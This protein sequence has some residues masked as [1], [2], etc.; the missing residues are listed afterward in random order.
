M[1]DNFYTGTSGIVLPVANKTQYPLEFQA[2]SRLTYYSHLFNSLEI[3]SSFYKVPMAKTVHKWA[4]EVPDDFRFTFKLWRDITHV[5]DLQFRN[6]DVF[7]FMDVIRSAG[8]KKGCLLVQFPPG[9]SYSARPQLVR[10]LDAICEANQ[11]DNWLVF[12]EF[13]KKEWYSDEMLN[14][15]ATYHVGLVLH[16]KGGPSIMKS[17]SLDTAIYLRFHGPEGNYRGTYSDEFLYEYAGYISSWLDE[18]RSVFAYF[19]NTVGEAVRNLET[20]NAFVMAAR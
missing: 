13:R 15:L 2:S 8:N 3:N 7:R 14:L 11:N 9:L 4:D 5:K 10:L 19:N 17:E 16:D 20:L 6:E 18:G 12:T 1:P